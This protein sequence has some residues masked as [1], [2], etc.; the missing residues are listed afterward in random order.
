MGRRRTRSRRAPRSRSS[1]RSRRAEERSGPSRRRVAP[2]HRAATRGPSRTRARDAEL[3]PGASVLVLGERLVHEEQVGRAHPDRRALCAVDDAAV[4]REARDE[5]AGALVQEAR[6]RLEDPVASERS[7]LA[8]AADA[9]EHRERGERGRVAEGPALVRVALG[10]ERRAPAHRG[11]DRRGELARLRVERGLWRDRLARGDHHEELAV[12]EDAARSGIHEGA[13]ARVREEEA[14]FV[15]R[16]RARRLDDAIDGL[17]RA[18]FVRGVRERAVRE[19]EH[20]ERAAHVV[21]LGVHRAHH[22]DVGALGERA[23]FERRDDALALRAIHAVKTVHRRQ[24]HDRA[25]GG[26]ERG[27]EHRVHDSRYARAPR[28]L[29]RDRASGRISTSNGRVS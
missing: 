26:R 9:I 6:F 4:A 12:D 28:G 22:V 21:P 19:A 15:V 27:L 24:P 1:P 18:A 20:G 7:V 3:A 17:E 25:H 13:R 14:A 10:G 2:L 29:R 8:R 5:D 11:L 16:L 23:R